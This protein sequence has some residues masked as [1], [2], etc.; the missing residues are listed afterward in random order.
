MPEGKPET[1]GGGFFAIDRRTWPKV[2]DLGLNAAVAYLVQARGTG[3]DNKTTA[4]SALAVSQYT[5]ISR[6][7]AKAALDMLQSAG[8]TRLLA[9]GKHPRYELVAASEVPGSSAYPRAPL[10]AFEEQMVE[11][12]KTVY[13]KKKSDLFW[14]RRA[15]EKGWLREYRGGDFR[16]IPEPDPK[17]D[18]IWLPNPLV[19]G[20]ARETPPVELVRQTQDFMTLR[21]LI[22][23]YG[24]QVLTEDGGISRKVTNN[25]YERFHVG[26]RGEF[27]VW[28][29][30]PSGG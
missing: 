22:D 19:T 12:S 9:D 3:G 18:W 28:G 7:K 4:W 29:F 1:K 27:V 13:L 5:G 26:E 30:R 15:V 21:M 16:V 2:C 8:L 20:A 24:A 6:M 23:F 17:P 25:T 11:L 10:D 14:A